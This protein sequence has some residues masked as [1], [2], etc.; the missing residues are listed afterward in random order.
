[1]LRFP[2]GSLA[3]GCPHLRCGFDSYIFSNRYKGFC[4]HNATGNT[5]VT[6]D[7]EIGNEQRA[8]AS[9]TNALPLGTRTRTN[10]E[11]AQRFR[12]EERRT[13]MQNQDTEYEA[14][15][16]IDQARNDQ[17]EA[18]VALLASADFRH[19]VNHALVRSARIARLSRDS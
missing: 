12:R 14:A 15:R 11:A 13:L 19:P 10:T 5:T 6:G 1:V 17:Q 4:L 2:H 8:I 9:G 3:R 18:E 16:A 7:V